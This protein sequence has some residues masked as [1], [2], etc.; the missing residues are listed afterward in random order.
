[1]RFKGSTIANFQK[2]VRDRLRK[3]K[4]FRPFMKLSPF[5]QRTNDRRKSVGSKDSTFTLSM[6]EYPGMVISKPLVVA[7]Q[8]KTTSAG[9]RPAMSLTGEIKLKNRR[10]VDRRG[11]KRLD[12]KAQG[13]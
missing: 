3:S 8:G 1:M 10:K 4:L 7:T 2:K 5:N 9:G 6:S 13:R 11:R 12:R